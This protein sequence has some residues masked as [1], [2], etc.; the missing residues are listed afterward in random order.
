M[1]LVYIYQIIPIAQTKSLNFTNS[2]DFAPLE[3]I[4]K[5]Q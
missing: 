3:N 1:L 5:S 2:K 4:L